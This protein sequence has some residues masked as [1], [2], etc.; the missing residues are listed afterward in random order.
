MSTRLSITT[1][2]SQTFRP[3]F[4]LGSTNASSSDE[5]E[6]TRTLVKS[7]ARLTEAPETMKVLGRQRARWHRGAI[8]TFVR[9][10]AMMTNPKYGRV[11]MIGMGQVL[12][13]DL[14]GPVLELMGCTLL[15]AMWALGILD[16]DYLIAFLALSI[17]FGIAVSVGA[18]ALEA[19]TASGTR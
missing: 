7:M 1:F 5:K 6:F 2:L 16:V 13:F 17:F 10:G 4:T 8:E 9:H 11:G 19:A 12:V 14:I 3:I 15:P 18:L